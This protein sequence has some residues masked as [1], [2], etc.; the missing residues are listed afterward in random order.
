LARQLFDMAAYAQSQGWSAEE[1]LRKETAKQEKVF[2]RRER[3]PEA[4]LG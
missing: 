3:G 4:R 2:R 1:L